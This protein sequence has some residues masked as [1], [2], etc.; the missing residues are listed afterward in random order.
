MSIR[1][2]V[3]ALHVAVS[4]GAS[5]C[6]QR[7]LALGAAADHP[8][9]F[10]VD[11][12][13]EPEW[14][15]KSE[16]FTLG[17]AGLTVLQMAAL[18]GDSH[19]CG[20]LLSHGADGGS[21]AR[22]PSH[23]KLSDSTL[24]GPELKPLIGDDGEPL[25]CPICLSALLSLTAEWTPCC[26]KP[27][28]SHCLRGLHQCPLCRTPTQQGG[29]NAPKGDAEA[30]AALEAEEASRQHRGPNSL[31]STINHDR[32][33]ELAFNAPWFSEG[34]RGDAWAAES[35]RRLLNGFGLEGTPHKWRVFLESERESVRE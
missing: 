35:A 8:L 21:L 1:P 15:E 20:L 26:V 34:T 2:N 19:L 5:D 3:C 9:C 30:A 10:A 7:L 31:M 11:A 18:R 29:R 14:D 13:D 22:M 33:L 4:R 32:A 17:L 28:H 6:V 27:F 16:S 24:I 25:E 12:D 23:H